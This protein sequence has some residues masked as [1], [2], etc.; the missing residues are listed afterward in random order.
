LGRL[1]A[2]QAIEA[3]GARPSELGRG[4]LSVRGIS[5]SFPLQAR[6][7]TTVKQ[8]LRHPFAG[9]PRERFDALREITF[10]VAAGEFFAIVGGNGSGKS[11]LLRC[12]AEI[13]QPDAGEIDV[14]GRIAP[15]I[16]LG[17]SFHPE[18]KSRE[19]VALVATL[20][21]LRPSQARS[22][23]PDVIRVAELEEFVDMP[24]KNYS[25]GMEARLAFSTAIQVD[26]D[27]LLFDEALDVGDIA[28]QEKSFETFD[29]LRAE[30]RTVLYVS[31]KLS[32]VRRLADRALLLEH[33]RQL[34]LGEPNAVID[35][36]VRRSRASQGQ[37]IP[38]SARPLTANAGYRSVPSVP[39]PKNVKAPRGSR[40]GLESRFRRFLDATV[41]LAIAEFRIRYLDSALGYIWAL[42]EPLLMFTVLYFVFSRVVNV[43]S[44][45]H[46]PVKLLLGVVLFGF[47]AEATVLAM[48][49]LVTRA[50]L[51]RRIAFPASAVPLSSTL[52]TMLTFG[53]SLG[54]ALLFALLSGIVPTARW[55]ELIPLLLLLVATAAGASLLLALLFVA[56]RDVRQ[57]WGVATRMLFF[58]TPVFYPVQAVPEG[59]R[60]VMMLNPLAV[61]VVE[62]NH[63]VIDA[64]APTA[65]AASGGA[66]WLAIPITLAIALPIVGGWFFARSRSLPE[67]I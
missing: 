46:Y 63:A 21:G 55:L 17:A 64:Q 62:A 25:A 40:R 33:G 28:F 42:G 56:L 20:I 5:K 10:E 41:A 16:E 38:R 49:S 6:S 44:G 11:T 23:S 39:L 48:T 4:A 30:G 26:A 12:I 32:T 37:Q 18:L 51:L 52:T 8:H 15:F 27:V 1:T 43:Q 35:E 61:V 66:G 24:V 3:E 58:A 22:R 67:R 57:I 9:R 29:R 13:Y 7:A 45:L 36:Y 14:R 2:V 34:A 54:I 50:N 47:F 31:H 59:M 60:H 53:I 19:N 65:A